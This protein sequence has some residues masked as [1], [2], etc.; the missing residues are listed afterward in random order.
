MLQPV[1]PCLSKEPG[2]GKMGLFLLP[3]FVFWWLILSCFYCK[4]H[5]SMQVSIPTPQRCAGQS[6]VFSEGK[7]VLVSRTFP[8]AASS[9]EIYWMGPAP[10]SLKPVPVLQL[11]IHAMCPQGYL[12]IP[13]APRCASPLRKADFQQAANK[14]STAQSSL[15][16]DAVKTSGGNC[17]REAHR[18]RA[19]CSEQG[20]INDFHTSFSMAPEGSARGACGAAPLACPQ[21]CTA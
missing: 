21:P 4:G 13:G 17:P 11:A 14:E 15:L 20:G 9:G 16:L 10:S 7:M 6:L 12:K 1:P 19:L 2:M 8:P 5:V 18:L 3:H